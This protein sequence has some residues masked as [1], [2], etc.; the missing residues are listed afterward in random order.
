M[1]KTSS[2]NVHGNTFMF[3]FFAYFPRND[4]LLKQNMEQTKKT[5]TGFSLKR[6]HTYLKNSPG[7]VCCSVS[8]NITFTHTVYSF[9]IC[10]L[11]CNVSSCNPPVRVIVL[12][13]RNEILSNK[14]VLN[15]KRYHIISFFEVNMNV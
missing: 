8:F 4:K 6:I 12:C 11:Q 7:K 2:L 9:A 13:F 5:T 14:V 3:S 1:V 10:V 15:K